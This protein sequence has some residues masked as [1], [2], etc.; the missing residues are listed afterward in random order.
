MAEQAE[1]ETAK[2]SSGTAALWENVLLV[3]VTVVIEGV[4]WSFSAS[5]VAGWLG[6]SGAEV[7]C[8]SLLYNACRV[9]G[10]DMHLNKTSTVLEIRLT[11]ECKDVKDISSVKIWRQRH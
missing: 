4:E 11:S 10:T 2:L 7:T 9:T 3:S 6:E 5:V 8:S 1:S